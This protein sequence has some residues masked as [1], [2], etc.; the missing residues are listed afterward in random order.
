M[1][2][3]NGQEGRGR[4]GAVRRASG[5]AQVSRRGEELFIE[6]YILPK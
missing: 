4:G 3:D 1:T 5:P 6:T 2:L